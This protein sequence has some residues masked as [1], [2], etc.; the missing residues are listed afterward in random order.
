MTRTIC[1]VCL[2]VITIANLLWA[3]P[4]HAQS[5][6]RLS[7]DLAIG[8][9]KGHGTGEFF[10]NNG[11]ALAVLL[12]M[13]IRDLT[14]GR[15]VGSIGFDTHYPGGFDLVCKPSSSG[16]C[17]PHFPALF[18]LPA[19]IGWSSGNGGLRAFV[20]PAWMLAD[21]GGGPTNTW[22]TLARIDVYARPFTVWARQSV[23]PRHGD[24]T[25]M[26]FAAG[27]GLRAQ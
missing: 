16:G 18:M 8:W 6:A 4:A 12:G 1:R 5:P 2:V 7:I 3:L 10:K 25:Y 27:V 20:G 22:G 9:S 13:P 14:S 26:T 24:N 11:V 21:N 15:V 19:L 23:I 17:I